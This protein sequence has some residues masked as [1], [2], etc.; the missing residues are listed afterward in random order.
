MIWGDFRSLKI[1]RP[2]FLTVSSS[3][4]NNV[5]RGRIWRRHTYPF[6]FRHTLLTIYPALLWLRSAS[7]SLA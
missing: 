3:H 1:F 5:F 6:L 2:S 7:E 4:C